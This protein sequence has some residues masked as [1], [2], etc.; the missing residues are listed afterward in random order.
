MLANLTVGRARYPD[1]GSLTVTE[2]PDKNE[3]DEKFVS[4]RSDLAPPSRPGG[5][6]GVRQPIQP[7][8]SVRPPENQP[9]D[10]VLARQILVALSADGRVASCDI[11]VSVAGAVAEL[12]GVVDV[13]FQRSLA[14][15]LTHSVS[16][17]LNVVNR[18]KV[19]SY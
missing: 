4:V 2:D 3:E 5:Y 10:V 19:K 13:E 18:L 16:G 1:T 12:D 11:D 7:D 9:T 14:E 8:P 15:A 17:V 6:F